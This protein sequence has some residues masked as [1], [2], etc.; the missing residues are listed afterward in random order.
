MALAKR[1][2]PSNLRSIANVKPM[3]KPSDY[4]EIFLQP[5]EFYLGDADTRIRTL[6]GSC[7][8]ITMWH[9]KRRLGAMCHFLV[10]T[11]GGGPMEDC[12]DGRYGDEA[13]MLFLRDALNQETNPMDYVIKLFGG[14]NM[15]PGVS[16]TSSKEQLVGMRNVA[17][18]RELLRAFRLKVA[19][20]N[21]GGT[22]HRIVMLDNWSGNVWLRH[23]PIEAPTT[24]LRAAQG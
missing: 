3:P 22:G 24:A 23:D 15:F 9:P 16:K 2:T 10:P 17:R 20:E 8:A 14:G 11:R 7:V 1:L 18:A 19:S 13:L 12:P 21:T 6:L 5:G 4:I